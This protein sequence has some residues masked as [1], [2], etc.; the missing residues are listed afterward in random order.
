MKTKVSFLDLLPLDM[1]FFDDKIL[2]ILICPKTGKPLSYDKRKK[3]FYTKD[4]KNI[5]KII[6]N[7]PNLKIE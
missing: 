5:Y 6:D 2:K 4:K 3:A 1:K 7:I